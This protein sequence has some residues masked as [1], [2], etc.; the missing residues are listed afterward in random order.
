VQD[1]VNA[2]NGGNPVTQANFYTELEAYIA[3]TAGQ[4]QY[5]NNEIGYINGRLYFIKFDAL[6]V[7]EPFQ[8]YKILDPVYED[9]EDLKDRYNKGS[10]IG[11]NN[12]IQTATVHWAFLVTEK[13]YVSNAIQGTLISI[14]FAFLVLLFAT[15]NIITTI[16]SVF[17]IG[18]IVLSAIAI[19][20]M[21][22]WSL[23]IIESIAIVVLI[24]FSVDYV[25]HLANHYVESIYED[26][27][28]KMQEALKIIGTSIV[29]GGITSLV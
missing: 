22:G 5:S 10:P 1:F 8:G 20:E 12:A 6:A 16:Y 2:R 7:P 25:V 21:I 4:N 28:R 15:L 13:E 23:G 3:T 9:W 17:C 19:M 11:I 18:G 29:S 14:L 26:R 27:Y 24:G